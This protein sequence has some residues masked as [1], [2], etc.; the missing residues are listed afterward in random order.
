MIV[1]VWEDQGLLPPSHRKISTKY[2]PVL[3]T[4]DSVVCDGVQ[5]HLNILPDT[6]LL[7]LRLA[8]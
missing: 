1:R 2:A 4:E 6:V 3:A 8:G 7:L 5:E